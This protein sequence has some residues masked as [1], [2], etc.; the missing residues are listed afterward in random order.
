MLRL[1]AAMALTLA[2][3]VSLFQLIAPS[4]IQDGLESGKRIALAQYA[5]QVS[6]E[7]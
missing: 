7:R 2:W 6:G 3:S 4:T 5:Q 1:I